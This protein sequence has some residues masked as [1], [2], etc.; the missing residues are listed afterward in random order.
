MELL[1]EPMAVLRILCG[2]WFLPHCMG[3]M[4]NIGP[5]SVT[6]AKAGF[7]PARLFVITTIV[8]ELVAGA[9]LVLNIYPR[10]AA[11]LAV[12]VLLGASYAVIK[13]NGWN[14]RWQKQGPEFMVFWAAVCV[15]STLD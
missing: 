7:H 6:F 14:W 12:W 2:V 9:G 8:V 13:I 15:L 11:A 4:R 3:K 1:L 10:L 5:A